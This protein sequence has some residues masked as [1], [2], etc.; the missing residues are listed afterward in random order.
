MYFFLGVM[1]FFAGWQIWRMFLK[2]D[3]DRYPMRTF[4]DLGFRIFGTNTRHAMNILQSIQLIFNVGVI[5]LGNGQGLSQMSKFKLCFAIC[6]LVWALGGMILGQIRT[7]QKFGYLANFAIWLNVLVIFM[8]M[9]EAVHSK[10]NYLATAAGEPDNW[11]TAPIVANAWTPASGSFV[12][13]INAA[14]NIVYAY[15]MSNGFSVGP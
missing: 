9:G 12:D 8:T 11:G 5:I 1:A 2:L 7:L 4:G 3:S 14:M 10:P 15:G 6:N 13:Q